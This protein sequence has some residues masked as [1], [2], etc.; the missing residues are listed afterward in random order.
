M[1]KLVI[2]FNHWFSTA[3]H[4]I[5]LIKENKHFE[6]YVIGTNKSGDAVYK[7]V[8]DEWYLEPNDISEEEYVSFALDFCKKHHVNVFF[9]RRYQDEIV[10]HIDEFT[11]IGVKLFAESNPEVVSIINDKALTYYDLQNVV[12]EVI[13]EFKVAHSYDEFITSYSELSKN[14]KRLCYK[15]VIDEGASSFRVI[16]NELTSIDAL[17]SIP[18]HK[19]QY[20]DCLKVLSKYDFSIPV[21]LMPYLSGV[22][23]SVDCLD[24]E[25]DII[26][27]PRYKSS[28]RYSE[29]KTNQELIEVCKKII[30]HFGFVYPNN[31]QFKKENNKYYLLEINCRMSG[32]LQLSYEGSGINI[33]SL[34]LSKMFGIKDQ[35]QNTFSNSKVVHIETPIK[36]K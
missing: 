3:Y 1:N 2:W 26:I 22:E 11:S 5:N 30:K 15:L 27:I 32:G 19:I 17:L 7:N 34:A 28:K 4:L 6:I 20:E 35:Y 10:K 8:C 14:H 31:I 33:P 16:D 13:P 9:I 18:G 36:I 12:P 21:L 25:E 24:M 23:V 29:I